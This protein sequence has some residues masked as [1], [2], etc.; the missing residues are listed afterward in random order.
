LD[1]G[2][3][4]DD[5]DDALMLLDRRKPV[6]LHLVDEAHEDPALLRL[7]D[8]VVDRACSRAAVLRHVN[9]ADPSTRTHRL[10]DRVRSRDRLARQLMRGRRRARTGGDAPDR[11]LIALLPRA[12][13]LAPAASGCSR[14]PAAAALLGTFPAP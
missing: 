4:F 2:L 13:A 12:A 14:R 6:D 8:E 7:R 5:R 9:P 11:V 10:E 1:A 3:S